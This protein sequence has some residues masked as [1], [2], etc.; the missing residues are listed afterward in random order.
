SASL[1]MTSIVASS[2]GGRADSLVRE[3]RRQRLL[4]V[5]L[6]A[7]R[8]ECQA[9]APLSERPMQRSDSGT[10]SVIA[11]PADLV[12]ASRIR[13]TAQQAGVSARVCRTEAEFEEAIQ[14]DPRALALIDLDA[15]KVDA[16]ALI[17]RLR[18]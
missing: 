14:S 15:R 8:R 11:L 9:A 4:W 13:T 2:Y 6:P 10:H 3:A 12:F 7:P 17:R 18:A 5:R 16:P 1:W